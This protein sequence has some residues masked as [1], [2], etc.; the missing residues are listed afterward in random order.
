MNK[1][2]LGIVAVSLVAVMALSAVSA[3]GFGKGLMNPELTDEEKSAMQ[4]QMQAVQTAIENNDYASW[5]GLMQERI[6]KMED[7]IT[8]ENFQ[9]IQEQHQK[10]SQL[11]DAVEQARESGDWS[12]VE[13]L[14]PELGTEGFRMGKMHKGGF[15]NCPMAEAT[16]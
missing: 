3:F 5:E 13:A 11:R 14:K 9:K 7:S 1:T 15:G 16:E 2:I 8:E 6:A 10:M 4:E 12:E